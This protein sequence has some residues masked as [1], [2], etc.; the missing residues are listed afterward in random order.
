MDAPVHKY[1]NWDLIEFFVPFQL[2]DRIGSEGQT[3]KITPRCVDAVG[4]IVDVSL[5][6]MKL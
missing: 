5:M 2:Y 1:G 6:F 3:G 4:L